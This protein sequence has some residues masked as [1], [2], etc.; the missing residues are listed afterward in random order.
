MNR[1][2]LNNLRNQLDDLHRSTAN[3]LYDFVRSTE[4]DE[5]EVEPLAAIDDRLDS[6]YN[7]ILDLADMLSD[8][9]ASDD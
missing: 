3:L 5:R 4:P 1:A 2:I 6:V 7:H 8:L 9:E